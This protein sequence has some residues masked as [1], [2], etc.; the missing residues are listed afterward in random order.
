[1]RE[2]IRFRLNGRDTTLETDGTRRLLWVLRNDL[3]LTGTKFGCGI[4]RCG[5]C[6]VLVNGNP[7]RTCRT[8]LSSIQGADVLTIE[9]LANG[10]DLHPLQEEF[11][12]R[13]AFQCGYC[14]SGMILE[15]YSLLQR[16]PHPTREQIVSGMDRNLCRCGAHKRIVEAIEAAAARL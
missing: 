8:P 16:N 2:T 1:M 15:A 5:A 9:G 3:G 7:V 10:D 12:D 4:M 11:A 6:T 14:T 13:G